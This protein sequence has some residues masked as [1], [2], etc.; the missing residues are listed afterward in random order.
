MTVSLLYRVTRHLLSVPA[1]LLRRDATKDAEI[2]VLRHENTILRRQLGKR[3]R[4][5]SADRLWLSALS[6]LI[7]HRNWASIFPVT[8]ATLL[9]WHRRLITTTGPVCHGCHEPSLPNV[10][11]GYTERLSDY[12]WSSCRRRRAALTVAP[13]ST[14]RAEMAAA[15]TH[16]LGE[17]TIFL[18]GISW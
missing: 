8:P 18:E 5:H 1:V 7:P 6:A 16:L 10:I 14:G 15:Q 2:H 13:A 17:L 9:S 3:L 11:N 12:T 4:Y